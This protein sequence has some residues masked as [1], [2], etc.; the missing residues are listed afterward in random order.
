MAED[1]EKVVKYRE[2]D[3]RERR[4]GKGE[5]LSR[6]SSSSSKNVKIEKRRGERR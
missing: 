3:L 1:Q 5:E 6:N 2:E 4:V